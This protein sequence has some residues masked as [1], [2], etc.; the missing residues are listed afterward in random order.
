MLKECPS[1]EDFEEAMEYTA[2]GQLTWTYKGFD[3]DT[4]EMFFNGKQQKV[5]YKDLPRYIDMLKIKIINETKLQVKRILHGLSQLIP[6]PYLHCL[7]G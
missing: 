2:D 4:Y 3:D 7:T 6:L 5:E 1:K